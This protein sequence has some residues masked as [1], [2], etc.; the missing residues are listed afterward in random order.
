MSRQNEH[1]EEIFI[2]VSVG[3]TSGFYPK[4]GYQRVP[5]HQKVKVILAHAGQ[6]LNITD[7]SWWIAVVKDL[8]TNTD[9][10]INIDASYLENGLESQ[11]EIDFGPREGGGGNA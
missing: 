4:E 11:I 9:R 1:S 2:G 10:E 3:T 7:T 5:I 6:E 8:K